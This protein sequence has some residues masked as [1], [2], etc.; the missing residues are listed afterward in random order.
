MLCGKSAWRS[1]TFP[2]HFPII[3]HKKDSLRQTTRKTFPFVEYQEKEGGFF[4]FGVPW[5]KKEPAG[6]REEE[7]G[8]ISF[9]A[10]PLFLKK[11]SH[12]PSFFFP[13][14]LS[15]IQVCQAVRST[16]SSS[17]SLLIP[18]PK[19]RPDGPRARQPFSRERGGKRRRRERRVKR[20]QEIERVRR[21]LHDHV[22]RWR[23]SRRKRKTKT[24]KKKTRRRRILYAD[25]KVEPERKKE[26]KAREDNVME[27]AAGA[28][29]EKWVSEWE[30]G[31]SFSFLHLLLLL[32][33]GSFFR[34]WE[35]KKER[36]RLRLE[37]RS[38]V[39]VPLL[40]RT[41]CSFSSLLF[42]AAAT[43]NN[44]NNN[45]GAG[46]DWH[47]KTTKKKERQKLPLNNVIRM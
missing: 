39:V 32:C 36:E 26:R 17:L 31:R 34:E 46:F 35:G 25:L 23:N 24:R 15:T 27:V 3:M 14:S 47:N 22:G 43:N 5:N 40:M 9:R 33:F 19:S 6:R 44:N 2:S 21:S 45:M 18:R 42:A 11:I 37:K 30:R 12:W 1:Y 4:V 38:K 7:R 13:S 41:F 20:E 29:M 16:A 28:G 8:I 10:V